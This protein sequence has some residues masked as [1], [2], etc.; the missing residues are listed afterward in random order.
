MA[1]T[2]AHVLINTP[3]ADALRAVFREVF[4]WRYIEDNG[5]PIYA[6]PPAELAAHPSDGDTSHSLSLMCDDIGETVAEFREKGI[7]FEGEPQ[8]YGHGPMVTM[9]LP[10]GVRVLLYEP[11]HPTAI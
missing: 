9:L 5:W 2:G 4:G 10:G 3:E 1:L 11:H 7:E 8:D 6:L